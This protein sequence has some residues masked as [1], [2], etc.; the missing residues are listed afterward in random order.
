MPGESRGLAVGDR[1][2]VPKSIT[3]INYADSGTEWPFS[4]GTFRLVP[5]CLPKK[6]AQKELKALEAPFSC[7]G[8][9]IMGALLQDFD[10]Q[11]VGSLTATE[12]VAVSVF[13]LVSPVTNGAISLSTRYGLVNV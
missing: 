1:R 13:H 7:A 10:R 6:S 4:M 9:P 11:N 2:K 3:Q 8:V 12:R 5:P